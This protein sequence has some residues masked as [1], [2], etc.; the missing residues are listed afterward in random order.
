MATSK[1]IIDLLVSENSD[2]SDPYFRSTDWD[3]GAYSPTI[4][5]FV[6]RKVATATGAGVLVK[7]THTGTVNEL[8]I[9]NLDSTITVKATFRTLT[10]GATDIDMDIKAGQRVLLTD[11][12]KSANLTLVSDS[13]TPLCLVAATYV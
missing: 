9:W 3:G 8:A 5:E 1:S 13:G 7:L 10:L 11:I 6:S 12:D 2:G 4:T